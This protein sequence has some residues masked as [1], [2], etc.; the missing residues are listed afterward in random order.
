MILSCNNISK[1]FGTDVI[2]KSC[3][4]NI[5]DHEKAAIVGINGAGKSTLLKIIT[6]EEPADTGI[7]TLAKDKTL[8]YLAQ[9]QDLQ[10][11]RSIYDE[12]LSVKQYILDMESELRR[13]EAAMN[14][15]SGDELDALM[16]RYTNLNH[17][18]EM[19]NGYAYKSEIT[20]VL[21]GLGFAE[22]DFSLHVNT[23][24]GGQKTRVSLGK[25]LLSK[26]DIIMLDEPTNHLDMESITALNNGMI[27]F[28]GVLLFTS[29]DHQIVQ[30]TA[31]RIME[32]VPGGKLIDKITTYDEYLESDEMAR[33]RQ[34]YTVETEE[35]D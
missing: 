4:F 26:P 20:G 32:I 33:K 28:P 23:L 34:T 6:G 13:I 1:S 25:L 2:I 12:L 10:S 3:S 7:V 17:E 14:S 5:E 27:K 11:D 21:K 29:R 16:N 30:T 9:Q 35:E 22:E 8:G 24:S 18:F 31:N 19:N 15:A